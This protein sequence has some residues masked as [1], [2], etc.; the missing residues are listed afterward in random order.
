ME[1]KNGEIISRPVGRSF[2]SNVKNVTSYFFV[3]KN[4]SKDISIY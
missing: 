3:R 2:R 4:I 1:Q